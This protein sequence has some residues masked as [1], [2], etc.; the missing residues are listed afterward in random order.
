M[1]SEAFVYLML[2]GTTQFVTAG[3]VVL[4]TDP[5]GTTTGRFVYGRRYLAREDAVP[6]DPIELKLDTRTYETQRL[7]GL[8]GA[9]RDAGPDFWGRRV[10]EKHAGKPMESELDY[11]LHSPDDRAG[12]LGFGLNA[13]PPAPQRKFN[14]TIEL[15]CL[16]S[17]ADQL[18]RV[19]PRSR[20]ALHAEPC[21][22]VR[23]ARGIEPHRNDW[24][25]TT[26][27]SGRDFHFCRFRAFTIGPP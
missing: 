5:L 6:I 27:P 3:R 13:E 10:I 9:L 11:L 25:M 8:F 2:P 12:L 7:H 4:S 23:P 18:I 19:E 17:L 26:I 15:A 16:Q 1:T 14:R 21:A 24:Q 20:G 22:R